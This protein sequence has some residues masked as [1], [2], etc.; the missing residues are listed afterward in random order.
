MNLAE[1][2]K[3]AG[4]KATPQRKIVY[5]IMT[6]LRHSPIDEITEKVQQQNKEITLSTIYRILDSFCDVGL[7]SKLKHPNGKWYFDITPS[8]HHHVF[9]NDEVMDYI[10]PELTA[11][12][13]QH[14]KG[15]MFENLEIEK[16][17]IKIIATPKKKKV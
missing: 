1:I 8:D 11:L 9:A 6:E 7:L 10:D 5:E 15:E 12:V 4:L 14:L 3:K 2:I 17:S 13:K 16:I